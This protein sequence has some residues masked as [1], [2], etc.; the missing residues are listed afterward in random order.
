MKSKV[1]LN[2]LLVIAVTA[3]AL[4][5]ILRPAEKKDAGARLVRSK[6]DQVTKIAIERRK[7][8]GHATGKTAAMA[9]MSLRL[10]LRARTSARSIACST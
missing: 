9:G 6:R 7:G 8:R 4:F 3:R 10:S 5:A 2:L 1:I